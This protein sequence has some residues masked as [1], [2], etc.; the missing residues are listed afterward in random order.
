MSKKK[1]IVIG[2]P[3]SSGKSKF[4]IEI[5]QKF[6]GEIINS[7]SRQFY[8]ELNIGTGKGKIS[9]KYPD[10]SVK[11]ND[12]KHHLIDFLNPDDDFNLSQFQKLAFNKIRQIHKKNKIPVLVGGTGLYI[13]SVVYNY[14]LEEQKINFKRRKD[15][16]N[17]SVEQLQNIL[18]SLDP[19]AYDTLT[20]SDQ[21]NP[22]RLVRA[23]EKLELF[24]QNISKKQDSTYDFIYLCFSVEKDSLNKKIN[25][26]VE[27][28]MKNGLLEENTKLR[29]KGYTTKL[30]SMKSIGY[31][32][33]DKY[34][35]NE[36]SLK[37]TI[38]LIKLHTRQ[39]SKRQ[40]TW[41]KKNKD[42]KWILNNKEGFKLINNF[43]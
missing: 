32:E 5:S 10:G 20:K 13:D 21:K 23:I 7:D 36:Q 27:K 33:F 16:N 12:I 35:I 30:N 4:A 41:F 17:L 11:I 2:G 43:L 22:H 40:N 15:L 9:K 24:G 8:K 29:K 1:I 14:R 3:T 38:E 39:Y 25:I 34:F 31:Q 6:N 28:M 18:I 37:K 26:R 19:K 42:I